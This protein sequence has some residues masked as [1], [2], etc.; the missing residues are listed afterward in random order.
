MLALGDEVAIYVEILHITIVLHITLGLDFVV[1]IPVKIENYRSEVPNFRRRSTSDDQVSFKSKS[2]SLVDLHYGYMQMLQMSFQK[3]TVLQCVSI[4]PDRP[5]LSFRL[6]LGRRVLCSSATKSEKLVV[7]TRFSSSPVS[8]CLDLLSFRVIRSLPMGHGSY[9][10]ASSNPNQWLPIGEDGK[11]LSSKLDVSDEKKRGVVWGLPSSNKYW[12]RAWFFVDG[13]WGRNLP[14]DRE[15][16]LSEECKESPVVAGVAACDLEDEPLLCRSSAKG[17]GPAIQKEEGPPRPM[18]GDGAEI[19]MDVASG[20]RGVGLLEE[21]GMSWAC[22][23]V[24]RTR[25]VFAL[26][27]IAG[28]PEATFAGDCNYRSEVPD[29]RRRSTSDD[30]VIEVSLSLVDLHYGYIQMLQMSFQEVGR[31]MFPSTCN[32]QARGTHEVLVV[33]GKPSSRPSILWGHWIAPNGTRTHSFL[34]WSHVGTW[35]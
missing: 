12:K 28:S 31:E 14:A 1:R 16:S 33:S 18:G 29:F 13:D 19:H 22:S 32:I 34:S 27:E 7:L 30:Q 9:Y 24:S 11:K 35:R 25:G 23:R 10:L 2:L 17:K 5:D 6:V 3:T 15:K 4:A 20:S 26:S 21:V 8:H